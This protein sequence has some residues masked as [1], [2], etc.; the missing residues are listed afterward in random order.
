MFG[1]KIIYKKSLWKNRMICEHKNEMVYNILNYLLL[2]KDLHVSWSNNAY[3]F[4]SENGVTHEHTYEELNERSNKL[5]RIICQSIKLNNL[6][7]N[8]DGDYIIAV[9][10]PATDELVI[11]LLAIWKAGG[12][13]L[14]MDMAFPRPRIEHI[15]REA[16]PA[17]VIYERGKNNWR[18]SA[19]ILLNNVLKPDRF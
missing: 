9:H 8:S 6:P 5:A 16:R 14:P 19:V 7:K 15:I 3:F 11:V 17:M 10:L 12:A 2:Q 1:W 18:N 13:Y 4:F